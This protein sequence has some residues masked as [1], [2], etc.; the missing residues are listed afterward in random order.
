MSNEFDKLNRQIN[1]MECGILSRD[2]MAHPRSA[3]Y[4]CLGFIMPSNHY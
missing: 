3:Y 2:N 4:F 1:F